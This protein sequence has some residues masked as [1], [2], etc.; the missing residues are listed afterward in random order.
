M[1]HSGD[2]ANG[3]LSFRNVRPTTCSASAN[4]SPDNE[5][6]D[7]SFVGRHPGNI[8]QDGERSAIER[9]I[10]RAGDVRVTAIVLVEHPPGRKVSLT[11]RPFVVHIGLTSHMKSELD[12][13]ECLAKA[14][15]SSFHPTSNVENIGR[16]AK[17]G[18]ND[19]SVESELP[20]EQS[21]KAGNDMLPQ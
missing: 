8:G 20:R 4:P 3:D 11:S 10:E 2:L 15:L 5:P 16:L 14:D 9:A 7:A 1:Y 19:A 13:V 21:V 12:L 18:Q 6:C 17:P